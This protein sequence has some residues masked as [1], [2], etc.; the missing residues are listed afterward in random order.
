MDGDECDGAQAFAPP[1]GHRDELELFILESLR[2]GAIGVDEADRLLS[3]I[4]SEE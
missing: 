2:N 3:Q 1:P 4:G